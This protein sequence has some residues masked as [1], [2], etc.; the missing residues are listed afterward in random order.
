MHVLSD[1]YFSLVPGRCVSI[2]NKDHLPLRKRRGALL[3]L[4]DMQIMQYLA[5][6]VGKI[7]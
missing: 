4:A 5:K 6:V 2:K 1:M 7:I 3:L